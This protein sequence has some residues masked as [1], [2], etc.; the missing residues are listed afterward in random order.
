MATAKKV[1]PKKEEPAKKAAPEKKEPAPKQAPAEEKKEVRDVHEV[2]FVAG[3]GWSVKRQ[4]SAKVIKYFKTKLEATEY[5]VK[6][7][8]NVGTNVVIKLKNGKYQKFEN[9]V[10]ALKYAQTSKEPD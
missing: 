10:R 6:V 1:A 4:N 5:V 8:G 9:A 3:K 7:A 2:A